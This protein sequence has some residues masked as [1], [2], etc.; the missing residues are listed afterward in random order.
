MSIHAHLRQA[1]VDCVSEAPELKTAVG[2]PTLKA[3]HFFG[4]EC[5]W[6]SPCQSSLHLLLYY[7]D[8]L[9]PGLAGPAGRSALGVQTMA[10]GALVSPLPRV[11]FLTTKTRA[12]LWQKLFVNS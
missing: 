9:R 4:R 2:I 10:Y 3:S 11:P 1:L 12:L 5:G 7:C 8:T 6:G